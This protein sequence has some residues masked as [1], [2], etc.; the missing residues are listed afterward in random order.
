MAAEKART[1]LDQAISARGVTYSDISR[2]I[3]KNPA[4]I[5]Q[6]IKRGIP[7]RLNEQDRHIIARYLDVSEQLLSGY[8]LDGDVRVTLSRSSQSVLVP[9]LSLSASAGAGTLDVEDAGR[10]AVTFDARWLK[11]IG[12]H[13]PHISIIR[14]D[15]ESMSPTLNHGDYI[16]VDHSENMATLR[17]GIYVVRLDDVL[18]VK[19]VA[20]GPQ[21]GVFSLLSDNRLYPSWADV[22][23]ESVKVIGRVVWTGRSLR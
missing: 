17:D 8:A 3:G 9:M 20:L 15:G 7:R 2:L 13:P 1:F 14:V 11:E 10:R 23:P 22:D 19:R 12:A 21:P 4:Y 5:Q 16:I 18:L 6:F